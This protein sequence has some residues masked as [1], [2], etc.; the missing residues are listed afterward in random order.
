V[1]TVT[2]LARFKKTWNLMAERLSVLYV[3]LRA[4]SGDK[5]GTIQREESSQ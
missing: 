3:S 2:K 4:T 1:S 5:K